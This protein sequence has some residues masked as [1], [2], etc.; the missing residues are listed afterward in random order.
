MKINRLGERAVFVPW[1][2]WMA[3]ALGMV[4]V[5]F[6]GAFFLAHL[7]W[8]THPGQWPPLWVVGV[9]CLHLLMLL[10]F[11]VAWR[12]EVLGS[13]LVIV[14]AAAFFWYAAGSNF[15]LFFAL[16]IIPA[17]LHLVASTATAWP[18]RSPVAGPTGSRS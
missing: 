3:R 11:L 17:L 14:A 12:W 4:V 2:R 18:R 13:L 6:W 1:L 15:L 7:E 5:C 9:L 16:T 8:F 10:G